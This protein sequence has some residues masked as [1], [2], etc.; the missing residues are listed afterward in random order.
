MC[1]KI[2]LGLRSVLLIVSS[3]RTDSI[4][5][6]WYLYAS[7]Q[8]LGNDLQLLFLKVALSSPRIR[9]PLNSY[10]CLLKS[11]IVFLLR[12][13][14]ARRLPFQRRSSNLPTE[15]MPQRKC[16]QNMGL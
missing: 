11:N 2:I 10:E 3:S 16:A 9:T 1:V 12:E 13:G 5:S 15:S 7:L 14:A 6:N 8:P 4:F